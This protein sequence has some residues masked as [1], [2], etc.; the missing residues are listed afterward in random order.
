MKS[1]W[2]NL[3]KFWKWGS[4]LAIV[5]CF[6]YLFWALYTGFTKIDLL[7]LLV[8]IALVFILQIEYLLFRYFEETGID[9]RY[10]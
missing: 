6:A 2:I 8:G 10:W 4:I 3:S 7:I 9:A 5:F 1:R